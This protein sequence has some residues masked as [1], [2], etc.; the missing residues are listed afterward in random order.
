MKLKLLEIDLPAV[1]AASSDLLD[2]PFGPMVTEV[3]LDNDFELGEPTHRAGASRITARSWQNCHQ[4][5]AEVATFRLPIHPE[6]PPAR[7]VDCAYAF[8]WRVKVLAPLDSLL[9]R[10]RWSDTPRSWS[11]SPHSGECLEAIAGFHAGT[12]FALGTQD[13]DA[14]ARRAAAADGLPRHLA[15]RLQHHVAATPQ[16]LKYPTR[17]ESSG[18][19]VRFEPQSVGVRGGADDGHAGRLRP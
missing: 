6:R 15:S 19:S 9:F 5:H 1:D 12:A 7:Q 10:A 13:V 17:A 8:L 18:V 4:A 11:A 2:S 16:Q 14:L 3:V